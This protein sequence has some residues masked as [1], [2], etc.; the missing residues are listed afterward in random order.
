MKSTT[1]PATEH[2]IRIDAAGACDAGREFPGPVSLLIELAP[3][4]FPLLLAIGAPA[5]VDR[6]PASSNARRVPVAYTLLLP[7]LVNA[8]AHLDL[9]HMGPRAFDPQ[10][11]FRHWL[12]MVR[13]GRLRDSASIAASVRR[14]IEL[15]LAGGTLAIGD[16]AGG[17]AEGFQLAP[18]DS[19]AASELI[20]TTFLEF[21]GLGSS[22]ARWRDRLDEIAD[23]LRPRPL[24]R[25]SLSP[26]SPLTV[27]RALYARAAGIAA[28]RGLTLATHLAESPNELQFLRDGSGPHRGFLEDLGIWTEDVGA[29]LGRTPGE[30]IREALSAAPFLCIHANDC[31]DELISLLARSRASVAYCPRA[32]G[33]FGFDRALGPHRYR[34]LLGAG[35]NVAL[36][37]DSIINLD[38]ADRVSPLDEARHLHQRDGA[39]PRLLLEMITT[40]GASA[41]GFDPDAWRFRAGHPIAGLAGIGLPGPCVD[42]LRTLF[43]SPSPARTLLTP[44]GPTS[45]LLNTMGMERDGRA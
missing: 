5:E 25:L 43:D 22:E 11:G 15:S 31:P 37:T 4:R 40:R 9:T 23:R 14:G 16:I 28:E 19:L 21:F 17:T 44:S 1:R 10:S 39:P 7:G 30:Y 12:E 8:H 26:H 33:Y 45:W 36:G 13:L 24:H 35:V 2:P 34:D 18:A 42:P 38:T 3:D 41:L 20:G 6:H 27:S 32:S 29:D